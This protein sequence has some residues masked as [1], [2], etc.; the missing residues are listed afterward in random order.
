MCI[1]HGTYHHEC[2]HV[3]FQMH[4]FCE[5]FFTQL[6]RINDPVQ[7]KTFDIPFDLPKECEPRARVAEGVVDTEVIGG[8][9]NVV[10]WVTN[11]VEV[12][13]GCFEQENGVK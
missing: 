5:E 12:C 7:R 8:G 3:S 2:G 10:L 4:L 11:L 6:H 1:Y 9:T 13:P